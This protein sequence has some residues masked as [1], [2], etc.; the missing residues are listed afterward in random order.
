[1]LELYKAVYMGIL[2]LGS[3]DYL[4]LGRKLRETRRKAGL[5]QGREIVFE[6]L[7]GAV[8]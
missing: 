7:M 4:E 8:G 3:D 6:R 1:M 2:D 5:S